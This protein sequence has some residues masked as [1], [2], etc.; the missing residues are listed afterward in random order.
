M[1]KDQI[2]L[3]K[4]HSK[5]TNFKF[6]LHRSYSMSRCYST[7]SSSTPLP[8]LTI[9]DLHD[10]NNILS[11][12]DLLSKKGGIYTFLNK[13]NGNQYIG[14]AKD[15]Y[16]RLNEH[17]L[18]KKSNRALQ[19]AIAKHGLDNFH[20]CVYEYFTYENKA[21]S[22]KLLTDLETMYIN[23]FNFNNL[24]NFS[25]SGSSLEG[26][27]H[28]ESSKLKMVERFKDK[29]NHPFWGKHHD[30]ISKYLISKPGALNPMFGKKHSEETRELMRSKK[31][32]YPNGVG[33]YD[34]NN[35]LIKSFDYASDLAIYINK[36]K[37]TV[38]KYINEGLVFEGKY[39]FKINPFKE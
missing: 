18:N 34:L 20:F 10:K 22:F 25:K 24:Y 38:S 39:Y 4:S 15:L 6:T 35:N 36:S 14:S 32:K 30:E 5:Y 28:T 29:S 33:I 12:R 8:I 2:P 1:K 17:L 13:M 11:K 37:V 9:T 3:K 27:K 7:S 26:Y 31:I 19:F 16:L 23:K 21:T